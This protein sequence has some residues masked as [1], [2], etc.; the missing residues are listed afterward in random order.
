MARNPTEE[1]PDGPDTTPDPAPDRDLFAEQIQALYQQ[2]YHRNATDEEVNAHRGNPGGVNGVE[3]MFKKLFPATTPPPV[4]PPP[5]A[6]P[7][8]GGGGGS[9]APPPA[10]GPSA[11]FTPPPPAWDM[12]A[13][14]ADAPVFTAPGY[15]LPPAFNEPDY[16]AA[17]KDPGYQLEA[18]E[19]RRALEQSAAARG[20]L[21]GGGTLRDINAWGQN[22]ATTRVNDVRNR[23]RDTYQLNYQT[24][25][26]DPYKYA[27][28][29]ALDAFTGKL[30]AWQTRGQV[31]QRQNEVDWTHAYT[32]FNDA[33][34][35]RIQIALA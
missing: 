33:W 27:Y 26:A 28:Q 22:Y 6:P 24:Q 31:G 16:E 13:W 1:Y 9:S 21:N 11:T 2:Y 7:P 4:V 25:Y 35:R 12:G 14:E 3:E 5:A 18:N 29:S 30:G 20:V 23:A 10:G 32:P 15:T 17:L 8:T 19:G 34:N